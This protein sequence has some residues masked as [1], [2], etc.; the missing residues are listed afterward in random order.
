VKKKVRVTKRGN[1]VA[2]IGLP[3]AAVHSIK[4]GPCHSDCS[5]DQVKGSNSSRSRVIAR[6]G[7]I[8]RVQL[9]RGHVAGRSYERPI[10][11]RPLADSEFP[12]PSAAA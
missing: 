6:F 7:S 1:V 12:P 10:W 4:S 9:S 8:R 5:P 3:N 11:L 2:D